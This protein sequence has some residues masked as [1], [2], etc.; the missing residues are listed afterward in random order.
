MNKDELK[1][2]VEGLTDDTEIIVVITKEQAGLAPFLR[3]ALVK[4]GAWGLFS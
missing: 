3:T 4:R 2:Y 1:K